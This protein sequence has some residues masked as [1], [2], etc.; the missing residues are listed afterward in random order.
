[1]R[2]I[3]ILIALGLKFRFGVSKEAVFTGFS[4]YRARSMRR[5]RIWK[6]PLVEIPATGEGTIAASSGAADFRFVFRG[7]T[8]RAYR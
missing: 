2:P 5:A 6:V 4:L 1:M 7:V 8:L 3:G